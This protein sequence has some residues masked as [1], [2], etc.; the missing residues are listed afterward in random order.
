MPYACRANGRP[1]RRIAVVVNPI[2][3][4]GG[5]VGLKGTDGVLDEA[6]ERG[7]EPRAGNRAVAALDALREH[8]DG[9][10][11]DAGV[12][13]LA[14]GKAMGADA[15]NAAGLSATVVHPGGD[16]YGTSPEDTRG[17]VGAFADRDVDLVLFV[18]GD[19]T[20]SDVAAALDDAGRATGDDAVPVLGVP[21][22]VKVYSACFAATPRDAG[23]IAA[24]FDAT[25]HREVSDL[26]EGAYREGTV[27][28]A[29]E[30]VVMV[31]VDLDV[32]PSKQSLGGDVAGLA[33]G[34]V[35]DVEPGHVYVLG[36]G[37]T[38][39]AVKE[40]LGV[41][42]SP[43][44]VDVW[45][46]AEVDEQSDGDGSPAGELL[47]RDGGAD[48]ILDAL[49]G[50][51]DRNHVVVSPIGGQGFL[52]GRGNQQIAPDAIRRSAVEPVASRAKLDGL[53]ALRVDTGDASLDDALR[54]WTR[55]RV[56]RS[57][58]RQMRLE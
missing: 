34:V 24:T 9:E 47:V 18:G 11:G 44:G 46:A 25:E 37:S 23:R 19:G 17:A 2:A 52:F 42:G 31:P 32:Q 1:M 49:D 45:R 54:G 40:A 33:A 6:R 35:D 3:G 15:A 51:P 58:W 7:A 5:R 57:E 56:G 48:A 4:M 38:M 22:G 13:V 30:A 20:A 29:T 26:D 21:A 39:L 28:T 16:L 14:A 10:G 50:D 27:A 36:P 12:E 43:L 8:A 41:D 53:D 55:V